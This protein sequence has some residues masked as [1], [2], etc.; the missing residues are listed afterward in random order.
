M[1]GSAF[2]WAETRSSSSPPMLSEKISSARQNTAG[3]TA[4][5]CARNAPAVRLPVRKRANASDSC[6]AS[7]ASA[8][9][10][11]CHQSCQR[12]VAAPVPSVTSVEITNSVNRN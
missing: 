11:R 4:A 5:A 9:S 1:W 6:S 8:R 10:R 7:R 12:S 3:R 2:K